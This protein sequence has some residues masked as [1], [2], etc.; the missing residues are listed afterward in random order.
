MLTLTRPEMRALATLL[1]EAQIQLAKG[2]LKTNREATLSRVVGRELIR[3]ADRIR[4]RKER[5]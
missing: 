1:G 2:E 4:K 3:A 5:R